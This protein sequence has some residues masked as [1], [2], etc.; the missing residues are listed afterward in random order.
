MKLLDIW[1]RQGGFSL[2][3]QYWKTGVL[4]TALGEFLLLGPSRTSLE[5]LRLSTQLKVKRRLQKKYARE[6]K[7]FDASFDETLAHESSDKVWVCWLQGMENAPQIVQRCYR[8]LQEN[9][10]DRQIVLLTEE[11]IGHYVQFPPHIQEKW[12][13]GIITNTHMTDLL[14]LEL[15]TRYGG[16]WVDATVLCT[17]GDL[18]WYYSE[19]ELFLYQSLKPG[20]DGHS[21]ITSSWLMCAKTNN[22]VLMAAKHLCYKYWETHEFM[23]DYFLLHDFLAIALEFYPDEWKKIVPRDNATPHILLLRLFEPYDERMW[24]AIREQTPFHKLSYKFDPSAAEKPNTFY[25]EL[26]RVDE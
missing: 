5:I 25:S 19:S 12:K 3:K 16:M 1:N 10:K 21:H 18:P 11:N 24:Q 17:S 15:L 2:V 14:R 8:S 9:L 22:K 23:A 7:A 6:L 26:L 20:R 13:R 4:F